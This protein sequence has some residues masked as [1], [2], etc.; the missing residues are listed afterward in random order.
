MTKQ[1]QCSRDDNL[2][3]EEAHRKMT[4]HNGGRGKLLGGPK[5]CEDVGI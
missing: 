2:G 5:A 3:V 4:P 1:I